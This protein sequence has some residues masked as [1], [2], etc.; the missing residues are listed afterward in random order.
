MTIRLRV[1]I[2]S[3]TLLLGL[4]LFPGLPL[5]AQAPSSQPGKPAVYE[6]GAKNC[7]PCLQMQKIM[8]ELKQSHGHLVEFRMVYA[9]EQ[10]D[11]F[12]QY[13]IMLIPTQVFLDANG[14]ELDRHIGA[15]S[16]EELLKKL[17]ELKLL[18]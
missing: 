14:K 12:A 7:L 11:L 4:L 18:N 13:K 8:A 15:L 6:F 17:N 3:L 16:K 2:S 1:F 9:D 5:S 10:R